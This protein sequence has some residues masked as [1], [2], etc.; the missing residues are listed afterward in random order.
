MRGFC[1]GGFFAG[2]SSPPLTPQEA[3]E[4][5]EFDA[6]AGK[7][8]SEIDMIVDTLSNIADEHRSATISSAQAP[9]EEV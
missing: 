4:D 3:E 2:F 5:V 9:L 6:D 8:P 7:L 1:G